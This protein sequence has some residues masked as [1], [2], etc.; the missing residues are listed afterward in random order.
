MKT[1]I[2]VILVAAIPLIAKSQYSKED[3]YHSHY[4]MNVSSINTGSGH[5]H[6]VSINT[7]IQKGN[8]SLEVG[9][10]FQNSENKISGADLRYK[11]FVG[12]FD[13]LQYRKKIFSPYIQYNLI[14]RKV[15]VDAPVVITRDKSTIEIPVSEPGT[16]ATMEHYASLGFQLK[17]YNRFYFDNTMGLGVYIGSIDKVNKPHGFGLHMDNYGFTGSIKIGLGYRFN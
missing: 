7:N 11:I 13:D 15:T 9:A 10:I 3:E 2:I 8:K 6:G 1:I 14:Y 16:I 17:L 5:G 4:G 12:H